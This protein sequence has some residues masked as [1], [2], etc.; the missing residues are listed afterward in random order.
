M[1]KYVQK[2]RL[3]SVNV[4]VYLLYIQF[5]RW[6]ELVQLPQLHLSTGRKSKLAKVTLAQ[7]IIY[8][9]NRLDH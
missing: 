6:Q 9:N 5:K 2:V 3:G 1:C 4:F 7:Y 8:Q